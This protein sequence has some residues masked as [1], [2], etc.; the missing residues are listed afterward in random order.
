[1]TRDTQNQKLLMMLMAGMGLVVVVMLA[2]IFMV[3]RRPVVVVVPGAEG[4]QAEA[5][6][7][8]SSEDATETPAAEAAMPEVQLARLATLPALDNPLDPA[9]DQVAV[10]EIPLQAQQVSE[11]MLAAATVTSLRV[12]AA[13]D[14]LRYLWRLSWDQAQPST[15]SDFGE[16][17]DAVA[18]Q[19][20]LVDGAPYTMGGPGTPVSILYWKAIWQKDVDE[21]FQDSTVV[22]PN[23]HSDLYWF[24]SRAGPVS[25]DELAA[26]DPMARQWLVP[27]AAGNPMADFGRK[28]PMEAIRAAG[29]G[30]STHEQGNS[31][32]ARGHWS[33]GQW[34]VVFEM[35]AREG[36]ALIARFKANPQQQ[37]IAFAVWDGA[38]QNRGGLK[39]ISNWIPMRIGQ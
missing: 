3:T 28:C 35:P 10:A 21:G 5:G 29:F 39:S 32:Q 1:M 37:L 15:Q 25:A 11:P 4:S 2:S 38:A 22:R 17:S 12:Q 7:A 8:G 16:F 13:H 14:G 19:F 27:A 18:L 34:R 23:A 20:P 31:C 24:A 6:S 33:D 9:W 36:D 30:T 26:G